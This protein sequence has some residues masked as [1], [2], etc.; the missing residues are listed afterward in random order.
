MTPT[1]VTCICTAYDVGPYIGAAIESALAQD[2]AGELEIVAVDDG[3]TDDTG[4]ILDSYGDRI[5]VV[6]QPN[7]GFVSAVNAGLAAA[8][9]D[10]L[11]LLDGDDEWPVHKV[12]R[13]AE[14]LDEHPAVGLVFGDME[15]IDRDGRLTH[16]SFW[17]FEGIHVARGDV[18]ER[19]TVANF[20]SGGASMFRAAYRDRFDPIPD[21]P[22]WPDWWFSVRIGEVAHLDWIDGPMNRYRLHGANMGFQATG[23]QLA[24][25]R[26]AELRMRRWILA[27][28]YESRAPLSSLLICHRGIELQA[29]E[30]ATAA[31]DLPTDGFEVTARDRELAALARADARTRR[32]DG[33]LEGAARLLLR[34]LGHDPW[35]GQARVDLHWL[36]DAL[37][38]APALAATGSRLPEPVERLDVRSFCVVVHGDE[39]AHRPTLLATFAE[40]FEPSDD[41][42]LVVV[43][44]ND[45]AETLGEK[46][47]AVLTAADVREEACPDV[48]LLPGTRSL[49][50]Q[51]TA[52]AVLSAGRVPAGLETL[53][54]IDESGS[55]ALRELAELT[56]SA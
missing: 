2:Y 40:A 47:R 31:G 4:A 55:T 35:D 28:L 26:R 33:D 38:G 41:A 14:F 30:A 6:H 20:A 48:L 42:T 27:N 34:A 5:T 45:S 18:F 23:L 22:P 54:R 8:T 10:Y 16:E 46:M 52:Q 12:R 44:P 17:R 24:K 1:R 53:P 3:S 11:A 21:G 7:G 50:L 39:L 49:R 29:A 56:W 37:G 43:A 25:N 51:G 9:G 13:Q 19:L 36:A 15:V 32:R